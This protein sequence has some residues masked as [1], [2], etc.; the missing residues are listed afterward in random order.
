MRTYTPADVG[1][2][3]TKRRWFILVPFAIGLA[4]TPLLARL[5]PERYRSETLIMVV[6]QR[7]PDS[8]VKPTITEK[9]DERLASI[10]EQILSRTR[11]EGII[12][13]LNL[14]ADRR[15]RQV[16]EDV[17]QRMRGDIA[18]SQVGAQE[19]FR[20]SFT[21][22]R[23][24]IARRV[25]E[26]LAALVIEQN[27]RDRENQAESTSQFLDSQLQEA[28][29]RL[30]EQEKRLEAYRRE[31]SGELPTQLA[32]NLQSIQSANLQLQALNESMN[33]AVERR[34]LLER[35]I[36]DAETVPVVDVASSP[37][38]VAEPARLSTRGRL[39]VARARLATL[40]QVYTESHPEV[41][42]A[43]RLVSELEVAADLEEPL[44][45]TAAAPERRLSPAEVAQRKKV[46]DLRAELLVVDKQLESSRAEEARFK[47]IIAATQARVDALPSRESELV[48]LTRDYSTQQEAYSS[49]L[50]KREDSIIAANLER[51]QIGEQFR[52]LDPASMPEKPY[53]QT[54]R[55]GLMASGAVAGVVLGLL[56]VGF[57]EFRDSSFY[58]EDEVVA[59]LALPVLALIPAMSSPR[60]QRSARRRQRWMDLAGGALL[61][62][63]VAVVVVWRLRS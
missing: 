22:D 25:T 54:Q 31:H 33:R 34:L 23:A 26:R 38:S 63:S 37:T 9:I 18:V 52:I 58:R 43:K 53:N 5:V 61:A 48:E 45:A 46:L 49:L 42:S 24:E 30:V 59:A 60:E 15:R 7:V 17:V 4:C 36:A 3:L 55:L 51:R 20:L 14:Y 19:A 12:T 32:G 35:Q 21:S 2:V 40:L 11:L 57:L 56:L 8:Y 47:Q 28:K 29:R 13:E 50:M 27:L 10:T 1:Q 44:G 16:M 39:D 62:A 41:V 6:P